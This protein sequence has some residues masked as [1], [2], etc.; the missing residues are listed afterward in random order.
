MV[1]ENDK[2]SDILTIYPFLKEKLISRN[3]SFKNLSNPIVFNSV[4]KFARI[5]DVA[6]VSGEKLEDILAFV[7]SEISNFEHKL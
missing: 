7:N 4:G 6:K 5:K 1:N 3:K 2:I